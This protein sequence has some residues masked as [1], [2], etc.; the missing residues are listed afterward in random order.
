MGAQLRIAALWSLCSLSVL[1]QPASPAPFDYYVLSLSWS[2][3]HCATNAGDRSSQCTGPRPY[4][5]IVHGL[6]PNSYGKRVAQKCAGPRLDGS[7]VSADIREIMPSNAL[8][9][10][11]WETHGTC[12]GFTQTAYFD[13]VLAAWAAVVI[14]EEFR[15]PPRQ[16]EFTPAALREMFARANPSF[17]PGAFTITSDGRFLREVRVCFTKDLRPLACPMRGD[18]R[19]HPLIVRPVR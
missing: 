14:P 13:K 16:L 5:F 12:T 8:I 17:V 18:T 11:E 1:A 6:W 9:R 10:H 19:D 4:G 15:S 2:P 3:Q 7:R